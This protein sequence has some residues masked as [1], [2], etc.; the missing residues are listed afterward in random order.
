MNTRIQVE[1]PVTEMVT[2]VDLIKQQIKMHAGEKVPI[3]SKGFKLRGHSIECRINAE[4]PSNNFLPFPGKIT[5]FHM[6]G[7]KGVRVDSHAYAGYVIP[8]QYDS[9]IGKIIVHA[10]NR[11]R[12]IIRMQ[13]ALEETI[14][15]GPKT[16]IPYQMAIMKDDK[17]KSGDFDTSFLETFTFKNKKT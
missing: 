6:P 8:S 16:T 13:R 11:E 1:H 9:M 14:I 12:A 15:D 2:G 3:D 5:S 17:F 7:G 10:K 4:D